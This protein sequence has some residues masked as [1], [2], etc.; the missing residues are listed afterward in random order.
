LIFINES[1]AN[2]VED[3]HFDI[4]KSQKEALGVK[5][6]NL[7]LKVSNF[8]NLEVNSAKSSKVERTTLKLYTRIFIAADHLY[9]YSCP[10]NREQA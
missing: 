1:F 2:F 9:F 7:E 4:F 10:L 6:N 8:N 3:V 5:V